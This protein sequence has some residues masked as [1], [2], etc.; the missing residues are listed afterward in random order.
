MT[1]AS[2]YITKRGYNDMKS[3]IE[4]I[5]DKVSYAKIYDALS[6]DIS[7]MQMIAE[8]RE[9]F[10]IVDDNF[11]SKISKQDKMRDAMRVYASIL[12]ANIEYMSLYLFSFIIKTKDKKEIFYEPGKIQKTKTEALYPSFKRSPQ[13]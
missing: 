13:R 4:D 3:N 12:S 7:D 2:Y 5:V 1:I 9:I 8:N 10:D 6:S 11:Y